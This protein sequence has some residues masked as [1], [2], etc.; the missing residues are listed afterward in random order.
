MWP[1]IQRFHFFLL[2]LH[3]TLKSLEIRE[4]KKTLLADKAASKKNN[5]PCTEMLDRFGF[6][7]S[8]V[9]HL[10]LSYCFFVCHRP[11]IIK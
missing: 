2:T 8:S 10:F 11:S 3:F 9:K 1:I 4:A 7:K 6:K 5:A